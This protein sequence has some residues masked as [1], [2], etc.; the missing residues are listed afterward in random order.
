MI[1]YVLNLSS[2]GLFAPS[3]RLS[4]END[5]FDINVEENKI[6]NKIVK[7]NKINFVEY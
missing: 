3:C 2:I 1:A 5:V 6:Y 7:K 4:R